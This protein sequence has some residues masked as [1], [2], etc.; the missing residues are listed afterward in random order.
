M[1][2]YTPPTI[3]DIGTVQDL[4]ELTFKKGKKS[5]DRRGKR[6]KQVGGHG[7]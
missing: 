2:K 1:S 4:T 7:S 5:I 6:W 3:E